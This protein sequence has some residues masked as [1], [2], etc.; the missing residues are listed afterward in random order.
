MLVHDIDH[1]VAE[2]PQEEEGANQSKGQKVIAAISGAK[3]GGVIH[4]K[5]GDI[6]APKLSG[7]S[8]IGE[9]FFQA[10]PVATPLSGISHSCIP[11]MQLAV[12][13]PLSMVI[14]WFPYET[15]FLSPASRF[16]NHRPLGDRHCL[17]A[18]YPHHR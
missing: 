10:T 12:E 18:R 7:F 1:A 13:I 8:N 14:F 5:G 15:N 2:A 6:E 16:D 11:E 9:P 17:H 4:I 3:E